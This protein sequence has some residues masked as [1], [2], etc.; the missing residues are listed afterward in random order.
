MSL[1]MKGV[2]V[3]L[4]A[5]CHIFKS[6]KPFK[7]KLIF[8]EYKNLNDHPELVQA[9]DKALSF[10]ENIPKE[11]LEN[12]ELLQK[13]VRI[14]ENAE[15]ISLYCF[16]FKR[17]FQHVAVRGKDI[18]AYTFDNPWDMIKRVG[19]RWEMH[20]YFEKPELNYY[21]P[22]PKDMWIRA[23]LDELVKKGKIHSREDILRYER[24]YR[25]NYKRMVSKRKFV[26][27]LWVPTWTRRGVAS[28]KAKTKL[29]PEL[30]MI[31]SE[32]ISKSGE[33]Y[34]H[35]QTLKK[36][37]QSQRAIDKEMTSE[38]HTSRDSIHRLQLL[39]EQSKRRERERAISVLH[40]PPYPYR[41]E[42]KPTPTAPS[43][44]PQA[45]KTMRGWSTTDFIMGLLILFG[46][47]SLL[48]GS[49][50]YGINPENVGL[51]AIGAIVLVAVMFFHMWKRRTEIPTEYFKESVE[52]AEEATTE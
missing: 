35:Y 36:E 12:N 13:W 32:N 44:L 49:Y 21:G 43:L 4:D 17:S 47:L 19:R 14:R 45:L 23:M 22:P 48:Y 24:F 39:A 37:V 29:L 30:T 11:Q 27:L 40:P 28:I 3:V 1:P 31:L 18:M 51:L 7:K 8:Y 25:K 34:A 41:T 5:P 46:V 15:E 16:H 33:M 42:A 20:G 9:I 26:S 50:I 10:S 2:R 6:M 52:K 38:L